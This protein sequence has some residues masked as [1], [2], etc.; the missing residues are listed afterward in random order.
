ML[1][2]VYLCVMFTSCHLKDIHNLSL[3]LEF[4]VEDDAV[5]MIYLMVVLIWQFGESRK[6][7]QFKCTAFR[8]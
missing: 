2:F 3:A 1:I 5:Y 7:R 6:Y 4:L 8:L